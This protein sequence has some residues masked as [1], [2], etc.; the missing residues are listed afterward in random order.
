MV[1]QHTPGPWSRGYFDESS[2]YDCMTGGVSIGPQGCGPIHLD[3]AYYGQKRCTHINQ[4]TLEK[5]LAD[6]N[7]IAAAPELLAHLQFAVKLFGGIPALNATA[8]VDAMRAAIA[9][10]TGAA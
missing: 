10:A 8:Q 3:A 1:A 5:V 9:K 4:E 7:L 2:G 6:A